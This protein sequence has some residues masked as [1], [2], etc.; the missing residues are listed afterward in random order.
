VTFPSERVKS[1]APSDG[2]STDVGDLLVTDHKA[3][4]RPGSKAKGCT[5]L[6]ERRHAAAAIFASSRWD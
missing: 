2:P 6:G 5:A 3:H 4:R 1:D